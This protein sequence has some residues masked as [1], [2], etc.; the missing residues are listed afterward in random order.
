MLTVSAHF[1]FFLFF[2]LLPQFNREILICEKISCLIP[3]WMAYFCLDSMSMEL[4]GLLVVNAISSKAFPKAKLLSEP[5]CINVL[6]EQLE[7][8]VPYISCSFLNKSSEHILKDIGFLIF[9]FPQTYRFQKL[10]M[11]YCVYI[12]LIFVSATEKKWY[13]FPFC[14][15]L[16]LKSKWWLS[17]LQYV[18]PY[19]FPTS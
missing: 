11:I 13:D 2:H 9:L 6:V 19:S 10:S 4:I 3:S 8:L 5:S 15:V 7:Q 17:V 12:Q 18:C 16:I 14:D 1:Y